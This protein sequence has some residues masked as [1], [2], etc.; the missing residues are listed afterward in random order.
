LASLSVTD[1]QVLRQLY[2]D[3]AG[4]LL[5]Y[6]RRLVGGDTARAEDVVQETL[7]R[8]WQHPQALDPARPGGASVRAWLLTVARHLVVDGERARRARP[9]EVRPPDLPGSVGLE[10]AAG[11]HDTRFDHVLLAHGVADALATLTAPHREVLEELYFADRSVADAAR[12]L[13]VPEGT[14]KSRAYYALRAL[15]AACEERELLP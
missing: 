11:F 5:G 3:H 12:R 8:A 10:V 9:V 6:V 1:E 14:V 13:G 7:L 2:A 15:R 4:P